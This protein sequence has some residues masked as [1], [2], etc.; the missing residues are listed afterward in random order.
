MAYRIIGEALGLLLVIVLCSYLQMNQDISIID[1]TR[2][3]L[4]VYIPQRIALNVECRYLLNSKL[5][6]ME[7]GK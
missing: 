1:I 4:C 6:K 5:K 7:E 3:L 2:I